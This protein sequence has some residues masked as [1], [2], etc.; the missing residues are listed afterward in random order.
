MMNSISLIHNYQKQQKQTW[1]KHSR[2]PPE[3]R[4]LKENKFE[5]FLLLGTKILIRT[6]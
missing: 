1:K 3:Y 4:E 5:F 6:I 2:S